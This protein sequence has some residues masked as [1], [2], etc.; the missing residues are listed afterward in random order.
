MTNLASTQTIIRRGVDQGTQ[1]TMDPRRDLMSRDSVLNSAPEMTPPK[2]PSRKRQNPFNSPAPDTSTETSPNQPP[3]KRQNTIR[4]PAPEITTRTLNQAPG[5][6]QS[7]YTCPIC[8]FTNTSN[9]GLNEHL[10]TRY[11]FKAVNAVHPNVRYFCNECR[12]E[13]KSAHHLQTHTK[14]AHSGIKQFQCDRCKIR[15]KYSIGLTRHVERLC[16]LGDYADNLEL[17]QG[18][19]ELSA[20][21]GVADEET[22]NEEDED[23]ADNLELGQDDEQL[24]AVAGD[25][26]AEALNEE[27]EDDANLLTQTK[28]EIVDMMNEEDGEA[29][30]TQIK[31]EID[32][33]TWTGNAV[34]DDEEATKVKKEADGDEKTSSEE[35]FDG[36]IDEDEE[37]DREIRDDPFDLH[38]AMQQQLTIAQILDRESQQQLGYGEEFRGNTAVEEGPG[39]DEDD[40]ERDWKPY[41][42]QYEEELAQPPTAMSPEDIL[43]RDALRY[44]AQRDDSEDLVPLEPRVKMEVDEEKEVKIKI[45][46]D[47]C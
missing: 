4:S 25:A 43:V 18:D 28:R 12:M 14:V 32:D 39:E 5:P 37:L 7:D 16:P 29:V 10:D 3:K 27:D 21:A 41:E 19:E 9:E 47:E 22:L 6:A 40:D 34:D 44:R 24:W 46:E 11:N 31:R 1:P 35:F 20:A 13:Y 8:G 23:Y 2:Q 42:R 26:D 38:L 36:G 15:F 45:E 30:P 17:G 33:E